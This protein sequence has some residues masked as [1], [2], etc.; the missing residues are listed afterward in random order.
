MNIEKIRRHLGKPAVIKINE[1][2]FQMMPLKIK[3]Y[4]DF[5]EVASNA[6]ESLST[7]TVE[8][9]TKLIR[10]SLKAGEDFKDTDDELLDDFIASNYFQLM[11]ELFRINI[12][13]TEEDERLA[14]LVKRGKIQET[15]G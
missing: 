6:G 5:I 4:P 13:K 15:T 1:D 11:T 8:T 2:E 3:H 10:E 12:P 9:I 14:K 7:K